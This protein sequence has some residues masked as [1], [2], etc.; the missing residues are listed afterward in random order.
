MPST[1]YNK[2]PKNLRE[3]QVES[4]FKRALKEFLIDK[5]YYSVAEYLEEEA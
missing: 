1:V 5:A 2:L 3:I 4:T